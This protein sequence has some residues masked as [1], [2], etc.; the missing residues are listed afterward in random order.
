MQIDL[1]KPFLSLR[2]A[3]AILVNWICSVYEN[4]IIS[5]L[6]YAVPRDTVFLGTLK[7]KYRLMIGNDE[8]EDLAASKINFNVAYTSEATS[9]ADVDHFLTSK[10]CEGDTAVYH[11]RE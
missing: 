4:Y 1:H 9:C 3:R 2:F 7:C 5:D 10:V 6:I 8:G 11:I